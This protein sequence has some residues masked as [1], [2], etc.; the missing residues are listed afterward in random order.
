[1]RAEEI[2]F[3]LESAHDIHNVEAA[4]ITEL[5]PARNAEANK[6]QNITRVCLDGLF[7]L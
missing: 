2:V 1:V 7:V 4:L 3:E 6:L 5:S